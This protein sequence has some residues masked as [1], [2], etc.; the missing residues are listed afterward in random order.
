[1]NRTHQDRARLTALALWLATV[2]LFYGF[3]VASELTR[4]MSP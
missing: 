4:S 1:M 3:L 2:A